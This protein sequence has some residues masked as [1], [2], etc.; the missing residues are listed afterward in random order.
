MHAQLKSLIMERSV[1]HSDIVN[2]ESFPEWR[3]ESGSKWWLLS[4]ESV[5]WNINIATTC[6][7]FHKGSGNII[8]R[9]K[10]DKGSTVTIIIPE[11]LV[12]RGDDTDVL[13]CSPSIPSE[14]RTLP[15]S[16]WYQFQ[17]RERSRQHI[18]LHNWTRSIFIGIVVIVRGSVWVST[19]ELWSTKN[20]LGLQS[21]RISQCFTGG[22][23]TWSHPSGIEPAWSV[24]TA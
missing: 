20:L 12:A 9:L 15:T 8:L 11:H 6:A 24:A 19:R 16:K 13:S 22:L 21:S 5:P 18:P 3:I 2:G 4:Q 17:S 1:S 23:N 7:A 14:Q 10:W